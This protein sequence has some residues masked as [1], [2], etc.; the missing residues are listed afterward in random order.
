[1]AKYKLDKSVHLKVP[2]RK[3]RLEKDIEYDIRVALCDIGV[4][5]WKHNVDNRQLHTGL[6]I[7]CADLLCVVPPF[8]R[9][10]SIEVKSLRP[11]SKPT[12]DQLRH[13]DMVR[14]HGGVSG[15]ARSV[16]E[17][18]SL[19]D[20]ARMSPEAKEALIEG[21]T[22]A[23]EGRISYLDEDVDRAIKRVT[24]AHVELIKK[25]SK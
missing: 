4:Q 21:L 23:R 13:L 1:M 22:D 10:L 8:G 7:G 25:L 11:G 20:E 17:A 9:W 24:R 5:V 15:V 16:E 18:L 2:K 3:H 14:K 6:G 19:V 12:E